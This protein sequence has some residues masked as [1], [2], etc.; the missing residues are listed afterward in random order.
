MYILALDQGTTSSRVVLYK[1]D[2]TII[3]RAQQEL[4]QIYPQKISSTDLTHSSWIEHDP[5]IIFNDIIKLINTCLDQASDLLN[6]TKTDLIKNSNY[7][8]S[9]PY[10]IFFGMKICAKCI[11]IAKLKRVFKKT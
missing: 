7:F 6:I 1:N 9:I 3:T 2:L 8:N 5:V 10:N 11:I 4:T